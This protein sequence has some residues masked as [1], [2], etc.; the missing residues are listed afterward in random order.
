[1]SIGQP[2]GESVL[3]ASC[4]GRWWGYGLKKLDGAIAAGPTERIP[5]KT[6]AETRLFETT[7]TE[8]RTTETTI[9]PINATT[10][11]AIAAVR[12]DCEG[13]ARDHPAGDGQSLASGEGQREQQLVGSSWVQRDAGD[14]AAPQ[15]PILSLGQSVALTAAQPDGGGMHGIDD[16]TPP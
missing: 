7:T 11:P 5:E 3:A 15:F 1:M 4:V 16:Q 12:H 8:T 6:L 9:R 13:G 2:V 10:T 14:V